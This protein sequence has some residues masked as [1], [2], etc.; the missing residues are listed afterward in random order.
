M[1]FDKTVW[2]RQ[3]I[4]PYST[5]YKIKMSIWW[6]V[7]KIL[8]S[9]TPHKLN[10]WRCFLLRSFGAKIGDHTFIHSK[11]KIWYP[12]NLEIGV[13]SGIGFDALI[14]SLDKIKIGDYSTVTHRCQINTGTHDFADP[15][16]SLIT[17]P[18]M[19]GDNVFIGTDSYISPGVKIE[20]MVII[21]AKSVVTKNLPKNMICVGNP[22]KPIKPRESPRI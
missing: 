8:F 4:S 7:E 3:Y 21:G 11:A 15:Y 5:S 1:N 14:Y 18:V 19:I 22:C 12:W 6:F 10:G 2:R 20:D 16:Y 13:H 9:Y 17:K